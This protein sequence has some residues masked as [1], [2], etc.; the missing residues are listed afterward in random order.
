MIFKNLLFKLGI[1]EAII[2]TLSA[3]LIQ[4]LGSLLV[5]FGIA[6]FLNITEQGY[7]YTFGSIL[8]LQ[9]FFELGLSSIIT[10]FAAH[11]IVHLNWK[12]KYILEGDIVK[13]SRLS[14]LLHFCVK[15]FSSLAL[16]LFLFLL[17]VGY[18]FFEYFGKL[19]EGV[20]WKGPWLILTFA[21][22]CNLIVTPL[23]SFFEGI[24]KVKNVAR[25]RMYQQFIQLFLLFAS[26]L[27]GLKLY[28]GGIAAFGSFLVV[29]VWILSKGQ[30]GV[31]RSLWKEKSVNYIISWKQEI[32]PFQWRI[33]ISWLSGFFMFYLFTP[34]IFA[35]EGAIVAGQMGITLAALTGIT[36]LIMSWINTKVPVMS[37]FIS[38]RDFL[39][40]D[41]L[42]FRT[43]YQALSVSILVLLF[44]VLS[45]NYLLVYGY[46]V[47][48]R[49]LG[50]KEISLLSI[51]T[52][53]NQI[54]FYLATYLRCH[55]KEPFMINSVIMAILISIS[56]VVLGNKFGISG[57][58]YGY[59]VL[60]GFLYF[61]WIIYIFKQKRN[62]WHR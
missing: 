44:F 15:W 7:Y 59:F 30:M 27:G 60:T 24:G 26:L 4:G 21:T 28:S 3:R 58:I 52:F 10:Q 5:I 9:M 23:L 29:S 16:F 56:T 32:F 54:V 33:A 18:V 55:K 57:I 38:K 49:F 48:D 62:L 1:D 51:T 37:G 25:L 42:F 53:I 13:K 8:A 14:S 39:S 45:L 17:L 47:A 61:P 6:K 11:E 19:G 40:L 43:L 41:K 12:D 35:T 34:I 31:I 36:S 50:I 46:N 20:S 2:Y 22:G